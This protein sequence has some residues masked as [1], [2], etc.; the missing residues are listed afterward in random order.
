VR[1][2]RVRVELGVA[3][4]AV[5]LAAAGPALRA[6]AA[7]LEVP[8]QYATIQAAIDAAADGDVVL[9]APGTYVEPLTLSGKTLT[10]ASHFLTTQDPAFIAQTVLD[11]GG[12][13]HVIFVSAT[14]G[15]ATTISGFT[16]QN[17]SD[18]IR[19]L[20]RFQLLHSR[21]TDTV[22]GLDYFDGGGLVR[23]CVIEGN[24]DDG[25]DL[26]GNVAVLIED[27]DIVGNGGSPNG[28]GDGIEI[29]LQP[30]GGPLLDVVIRNNRIEGNTSD[31][32]Q[33]I[34]Y[35]VATQRA[36]RIEG[37]TFVDNRLA[38]IGMMCCTQSNEDF[39]GA[40][41]PER[42]L[43][44]RNTFVGN[45]HGISGGDNVVALDNLFV[46][47]TDTALHRVDGASIAAY[48][49]FW[50]NGSDSVASNVDAATSLGLDPLLD[51]E[52]ELLPGSPAEDAGTAT[53]VHLGEP[54]LDLPPSAFAGSAPDLGAFEVGS[55][56]P[57]NEPPFVDAGR[58]QVLPSGS[59]ALLEGGA[60]DDGLPE[61]TLDVSW[62]VVSGPGSVSFGD[63][64]AEET[65]ASFSQDGSYVLRLSADDSDLTASDDVR[66]TLS[67]DAT[68]LERSVIAGADD[69]EE[70][71]ASGAVDLTGATLDLGDGGGML[72][73]LR[74]EGIDVPPGS[75]VFTA[76]V[77]L[78]SA[79]VDLDDA[80]IEIRGELA[81]DAAPFQAVPGNLS[82]RPHTETWASWQPSA[83]P[84]PGEAAAAQRTADVSAVIGEIVDGP[85]WQEGNALALFLEGSGLRRAEAFEGAAGGEARLQL[86]FAP[87]PPNQPPQ[88]HAGPDR[89]IQ[90]GQS[91]SLDGSFA[92]D[93]LPDGYPLSVLWN[94]VS[95]PGQATVAVPDDP[96]THAVFSTAG[97]YVL[98]LTAHD[99][100]LSASDTMQVGV[101]ANLPPVVDAGP[102]RTVVIPDPLALSGNVVDDGP[103][104]S[105]SLLWTAVSGPGAVT[106]GAPTSASTQA[107][108]SAPGTYVLRLTA[109]DGFATAWDQVTVNALAN[110]PPVVTV[111]PPY[112][113][114]V[115]PASATLV[116]SASDDGLPTGQLSLLW[117]RAAGPGTV[118]FSAP[119][120]AAT[121][122]SFSEPGSYLL[123]LA[124][125]DGALSRWAQLQ[126]LV[127]E[128]QPPAVE[129]GPD[130]TLV[131]P[132]VASLAGSAGDDGLPGPDLTYQWSV[133]SGPAAVVFS[134]PTDLGTDAQFSEP[135][136]Y[137]LRLV[138]DDGELSTGDTLTVGVSL[139][140]A[141]SL[142]Q[143]AVAASSDDAEE[144]VGD[145]KARLTSSDLELVLDIELQTVGMRF[146]GVGILP[147][148][149]IRDA[150]LQLRADESHSGPVELLI[151]GQAADDPVTFA[152]TVGNI[153][154]RPRTAAGAA[155]SPPPW[156][157]GNVVDSPSLAAVVQEVVDRP[158]WTAGNALVLIVTGT[159]RRTATSY[160]GSSAGAPRLFVDVQ[161]PSCADGIDNDGDGLADFPADPGC[162]DAGSRA[163]NP[164]CSDGIDN[165]G[166]GSADHPDDPGCAD[167][168]A[169]LELT[170]TD[171]DGLY[172]DADNCILAANPSQADSNGDGFGNA[173]DLDL[174]DDGVVGLPDYGT[175]MGAF[176]RSCGDPAWNPAADVNDDCVVGLLDFG[177]LLTSFGTP[178]GPSALVP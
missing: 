15:P 66:I 59:L 53:Y 124:A 9:V 80:E 102:D 153:S 88:V 152:G 156:T 116:G 32:I 92:D 131:L 58:D 81:A 35:D 64:L 16:I 49:G 72:V 25:I 73:A 13:D 43:V 47:T 117:T 133:E 164:A 98:R 175:L 154:D 83:W 108:F 119:N 134:A 113:E 127:I 106:F 135:G 144:P 137:V 151:Q 5:V 24:S 158:G 110:Q 145:R 22:D 56:D 57:A 39:Q 97:L 29:R 1:L 105:V 174:D 37:N 160:N 86:T 68:I 167:A 75:Q 40:S 34:G 143:V 168:A 100:E 11:G 123:R 12:D 45:G 149:S 139:P 111:S 93:G 166:N 129:A 79:A 14:V 30:Y 8:A 17:A 55:V 148:S 125:N 107:W 67:P 54:V 169:D 3:A 112:Q 33:L 90:L 157:A 99:G 141:T 120:A 7:T 172:D 23:S 71:L 2:V 69:A 101:V 95:G 78:Q 85:A 61:G 82:A 74:F 146:A 122:A 21:I 170:D 10:L 52:L 50:Q 26:D 165:D 128:N 115:L 18:G 118:T 114:V 94:Q 162:A 147:G 140:G 161:A 76:S 132:E 121:Q 176:G 87:P 51:A 142:L 171:A 41:L 20:G 84:Q 19:A 46:S 163:E 159:G 70:T 6:G 63:P 28:D 31:G 65:T 104:G 27:N 155:W 89:V 48:N 91:A 44:V 136:V 126:V 109:D 60:D 130:Q 138:A 62:S 42:V 177:A 173:C 4:L 103:P 150:W 178:P 36:F 77:Q 38:A 96:A